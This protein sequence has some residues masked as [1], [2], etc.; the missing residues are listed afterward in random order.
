MLLS[1]PLPAVHRLKST[2]PCD[3]KEDMKE[4]DPMSLR[5][6]ELVA[7]V[8]QLRRQLTE[9]D[10]EI[11]QL[12]LQLAEKRASSSGDQP[13]QRTL[14]SEPGGPSPGSQQDLLVQLEKIYPEGR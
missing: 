12:K 8:Q 2:I 10:Q 14:P 6:D 11:E 4:I 9:R 7:L 5:P 3:E 1:K 13:T